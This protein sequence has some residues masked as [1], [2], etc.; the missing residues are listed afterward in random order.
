MLE[1]PDEDGWLPSEVAMLRH[2]HGAVPPLTHNFWKEVSLTLHKWHAD[3]HKESGRRGQVAKMVGHHSAQACQAKWFKCVVDADP[4]VAA[5]G[6][7]GGGNVK[8][9]KASGPNPLLAQKFGGK[10]TLK[11]RKQLR[12]FAEQVRHRQLRVVIPSSFTLSALSLLALRW[13]KKTKGRAMCSSPRLTASNSAPPQ[14]P[15]RA[16]LAPGNPLAR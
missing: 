10:G 12:A 8:G 13:R 5:G 3:H 7:R 11:R 14:R 9:K 2:A 1:S 4:G 15:P 6:A 16:P